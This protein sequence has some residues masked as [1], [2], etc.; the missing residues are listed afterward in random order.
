ML[1]RA[2]FIA[3]LLP[4][5]SDWTTYVNLDVD[6]DYPNFEA[7]TLG[8]LSTLSLISVIMHGSRLP[9]T[10]KGRDLKGLGTI[11]VIDLAGV[12]EDIPK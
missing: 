3:I 9:V 11:P 6:M 1:A 10:F 8:R 7:H 2:T 5:R 12:C 4:P